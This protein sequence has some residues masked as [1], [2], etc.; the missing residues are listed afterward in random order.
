MQDQAPGTQE[1]Q[2]SSRIPWTRWGAIREELGAL[3][4]EILFEARRCPPDGRE[5][6]LLDEAHTAIGSAIEKIEL[7]G[8]FR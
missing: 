2:R 5:R 7:A 8:R 6:E 3:E 1:E 4:T